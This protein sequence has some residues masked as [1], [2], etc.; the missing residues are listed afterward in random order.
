VEATSVLGYHVPIK[1]KEVLS[2]SSAI[3]MFLAALIVFGAV[4]AAFLLIVK[5]LNA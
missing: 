1:Q 4:I 5:A 3:L 2:M